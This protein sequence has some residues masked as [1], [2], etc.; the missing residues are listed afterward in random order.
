[1]GVSFAELEVTNVNFT[2]F[3]ISLAEWNSPNIKV[4]A[5]YV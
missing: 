4:N 2:I 3:H 5:H 1:M